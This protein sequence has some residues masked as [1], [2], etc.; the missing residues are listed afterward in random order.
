[1]HVPEQEYTGVPVAAI[2][3]EAVPI[4]GSKVLKVIAA[5]GYMIEFALD[6]ILNDDKFLLIEEEEAAAGLDR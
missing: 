4:P 6:K 5:D 2:I 3:Q 1:M